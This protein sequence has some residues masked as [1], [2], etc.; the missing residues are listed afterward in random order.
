VSDH[1]DA[2]GVYFAYS[3]SNVDVDGLAT[4]LA[5]DDY[6]RGRTGK[7][8]LD[9]YAGGA[10]WTHYGPSGWYLD[11]IF[12]GT[13][14]QGHATTPFAHL[15]IA[16]DGLAA[17][18]ESGYPISLPFGPQFVLEPQMQVIGQRVSFAQAYDGLGPVDRD[19]R[20]RVPPAGWACAASGPSS[21]IVATSGSRTCGGIYGMTGVAAR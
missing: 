2:I 4:D 16:G 9:A 14:Y 17:S 21:A 1:R 15:P 5:S 3:N 6:V 18:L 8:N 13:S 20:L 11:G 19:M 10:Y 7:V 12:Q